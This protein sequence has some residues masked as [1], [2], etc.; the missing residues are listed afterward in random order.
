MFLKQ[1]SFARYHCHKSWCPIHDV[2]TICR[3]ARTILGNRNEKFSPFSVTISLAWRCLDS[4][5]PLL[6]NSCTF[7]HTGN[8]ICR[9]VEFS[10][11]LISSQCCEIH[12]GFG[13]FFFLSSITCLSNV[14][15]CDKVGS[16]KFTLTF[17]SLHKLPRRSLLQENW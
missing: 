10:C 4:H 8:L 3:R 7:S 15:H 11:K 16:H 9:I 6:M 14:T 5:V 2:L 17:I 1:L 13:I 12:K